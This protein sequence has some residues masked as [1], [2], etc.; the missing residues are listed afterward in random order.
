LLRNR[1]SSKGNKP[2]HWH[3]LNHSLAQV[4][5]FWIRIRLINNALV[6]DINMSWDQQHFSHQVSNTGRFDNEDFENPRH[7]HSGKLFIPVFWPGPRAERISPPDEIENLI[8]RFVVKLIMM[9]M[10]IWVTKRIKK[11]GPALQSI[12]Q[13]VKIV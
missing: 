2:R 11:S 4:K 10:T 5:Q 13:S 1:T 8:L 9:N 3:W 6:I 7:N 12:Q